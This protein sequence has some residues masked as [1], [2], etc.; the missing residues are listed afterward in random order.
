MSLYGTTCEEL[1]DNSDDEYYDGLSIYIGDYT[2]N[3]FIDKSSDEGIHVSVSDKIDADW[4][5]YY[6]KLY[7]ETICLNKR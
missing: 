2:M 5:D 6:E 1:Y 3:N 7:V 4:S